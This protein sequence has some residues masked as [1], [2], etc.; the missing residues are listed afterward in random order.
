MA[1]N[2]SVP[3]PRCG[4][5]LDVV[6]QVQ[7]EARLT[8]IPHAGFG[9]GAIKQTVG[10]LRRRAELDY[11]NADKELNLGERGEEEDR[12]EGEVVFCG[13][14]DFSGRVTDDGIEE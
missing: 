14:C 8:Q 12:P 2:R 3:C 4:E 6:L 11:C 9:I 10:E 7:V 5:P 13:S 1:G